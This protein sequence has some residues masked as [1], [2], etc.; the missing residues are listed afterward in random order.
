MTE[1]VAEQKYIQFVHLLSHNVQLIQRFGGNFYIFRQQNIEKKEES[2]RLAS[3]SAITFS[4]KYLLEQ[5]FMFVSLIVAKS[6][7]FSYWF[8]ILNSWKCPES[9]NV[10]REGQSNRLLENKDHVNILHTKILNKP[11]EIGYEISK[12]IVRVF[13]IQA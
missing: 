9:S 1:Q 3:H 12:W 4:Y 10:C 11:C 6:N 2:S 8:P 7:Q 13:H 5:K